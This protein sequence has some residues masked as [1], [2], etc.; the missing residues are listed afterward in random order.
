MER[1]T[2]TLLPSTNGPFVRIGRHADVDVYHGTLHPAVEV[3]A[4]GDVAATVDEAHAALMDNVDPRVIATIAES[5]VSGAA[6]PTTLLPDGLV[7]PVAND[8]EFALYAR[9]TTGSPVGFAFE[10]VDNRGAITRTRNWVDRIS[11]SWGFD[12]IDDGRATRVIYHARIELAKPLARWTVRNGA[13]RD[14]PTLIEQLRSL[15]TPRPRHA[16]VA[17]SR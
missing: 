6:P 9:W 17:N 4:V 7:V 14:L 11:G 3:A 5:W 13:L 16:S 15:V 2:L 10:I 8:R 1:S 12:P